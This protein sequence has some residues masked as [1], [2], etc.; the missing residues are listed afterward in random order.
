MTKRDKEILEAT[1]Q[2]AEL[3]RDYTPA[4]LW[5]G[6]PKRSREVLVP[7]QKAKA[8]ASK[9]AC[10]VDDPK[11]V[12]QASRLETAAA[13][14]ELNFAIIDKVKNNPT[15]VEDLTPADIK[16]ML[17]WPRQILLAMVEFVGTHLLAKT[18]VEQPREAAVF[19]RLAKAT[20][21]SPAFGM[22]MVSGLDG[23][24]RVQETLV[25]SFAEGLTKTCT[26]AAF[27]TLCNVLKADVTTGLQRVD[28]SLFDVSL[29]DPTNSFSSDG[30]SKQSLTD[31]RCLLSWAY[32]VDA[33]AASSADIRKLAVRMMDEKRGVSLR[34]RA[35]RGRVTQNG[36]NDIGRFA[37]RRL[38]ELGD[39]SMDNQKLERVGTA[40]Q[41]CTAMYT[42]FPKVTD[43]DEGLNSRF[44]FIDELYNEESHVATVD[45]LL[46]AVDACV[47][48][49]LDDEHVNQA[50]ALIIE[51]DTTSTE[52]LCFM[53]S[54]RSSAVC[55]DLVTGVSNGSIVMGGDSIHAEDINKDIDFLECCY[56]AF[57]LL[58]KLKVAHMGLV[59]V[60]PVWRNAP[61]LV[62]AVFSALSAQCKWAD[63]D[64]KTE[65]AD[66]K[67]QKTVDVATHLDGF[68]AAHGKLKDAFRYWDQQKGPQGPATL[69]EPYQEIDRFMH[70]LLQ[71]DMTSM[72]R[73]LLEAAVLPASLE[74]W[75]VIESKIGLLPEKVGCVCTRAIA[76][77]RGNAAIEKRDCAKGVGIPEWAAI[78]AAARDTQTFLSAELN[79]ASKEVFD[80]A[81]AEFEESLLDFEQRASAKDF[82][83][84]WD[85]YG[86]VP[87][88]IAKDASGV[89]WL[90]ADENAT[91][92]LQRFEHFRS[93][94]ENNR[95]MAQALSSS[96]SMH[97]SAQGRIL[98]V[99]GQ[100]DEVIIHLKEIPMVQAHLMI[101]LVVYGEHDS[102][103]EQFQSDLKGAR[104]FVTNKSKLRIP[105]PAWPQGLK[106][107]YNSAEAGAGV[108]PSVAAPSSSVSAM[109]DAAPAPAP[110]LE[111][112]SSSS[113]VS[114]TAD[115]TSTPVTVEP[116][117]KKSRLR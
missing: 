20:S 16:R 77:H 109:P 6:P 92:A 112:T 15:S 104:A 38:D 3:D 36:D 115:A 44:L 76:Y 5:D 78:T 74:T 67:K 50:R 29:T 23:A 75:Y 81:D 21:I 91:A 90:G 53:A 37:W 73:D 49:D 95:R 28:R 89:K 33:G 80:R 99:K 18:T 43:G 52:T 105:F 26:K 65:M 84:L 111:A 41:D 116:K 97:P 83:Q 22:T 88:Q 60:G 39:N 31:L 30:W 113:S 86:P 14:V 87:E 11:L 24:A 1:S 66:G 9:L 25:V 56:H 46:E 108:A 101:L 96:L 8:A 107:V 4:M 17:R 40:L 70:A 98:D 35:F 63:A 102:R 10:R 54:G 48:A 79:T 58:H 27:V 117:A 55:Q 69:G 2:E 59:A 68:A 61:A 34:L 19:L 85:K 51:I 114:A 12:E 103:T 57:T 13:E 94:A 47:A 72:C 93:T 82:L 42:S 106:D 7:A 64:W 100:L 71:F 32:A 62:D 110:S 45:A